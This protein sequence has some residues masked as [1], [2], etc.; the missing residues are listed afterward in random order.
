MK[1]QNESTI[2]NRPPGGGVGSELPVLAG[3]S[4]GTVNSAG[5]RSNS[6]TVVPPAYAGGSDVGGDASDIDF[7]RAENEQLKTTIRTAAAHR[8]ITGELERAGARSP[9]L[10]FDS[11]KAELQFAGDGSVVNSSALVERLRRNF[12]EQFGYDRPAASIDGGA[13]AATAPQLTKETLAKMKPAEI[14]ELD[15]ADVKRVLAGS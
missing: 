12:P 14:A 11:I 15:W 10:L 8:Q 9:G 5:Q 4:N 13:G 7:L 1:N 6:A 2:Q 3:G